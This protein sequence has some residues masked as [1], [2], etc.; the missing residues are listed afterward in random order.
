MNGDTQQ[1]NSVLSILIENGYKLS[2]SRHPFD[3]SISLVVSWK[4]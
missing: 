1:K 3:D 2:C 4:T